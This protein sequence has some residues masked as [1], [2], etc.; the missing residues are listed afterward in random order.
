M[1]V[2]QIKKFPLYDVFQGSGWT[3]WTRE[4]RQGTNLKVIDGAPLTYA[5]MESLAIEI[6]N[7]AGVTRATNRKA[8]ERAKADLRDSLLQ[9]AA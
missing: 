6:L 9:K 5:I 1:V 8:V 2:H 3:G 7:L 4:L